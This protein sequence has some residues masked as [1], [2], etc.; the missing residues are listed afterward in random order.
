MAFIFYAIFLSVSLLLIVSLGIRYFKKMKT[1]SKEYP[2]K[3]EIREATKLIDKGVLIIGVTA[4][5]VFV[6]VFVFAL[7]TQ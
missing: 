1:F 6:G 7:A 2:S 4:V 5:V 3:K